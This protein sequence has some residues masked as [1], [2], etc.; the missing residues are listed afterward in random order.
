MPEISTDSILISIAKDGLKTRKQSPSPLKTRDTDQFTRLCINVVDLD[1]K[2][3]SIFNMMSFMLPNKNQRSTYN[4]K[5]DIDTART[6]V[7]DSGV[8]I[9]SV[10]LERPYDC[11]KKKN[12]RIIEAE[13]SARFTESIVFIVTPPNSNSEDYYKSDLGISTLID[14]KNPKNDPL[15]QYTFYHEARLN[16]GIPEKDIIALLVPNHLVETVK[17]YFPT[18]QIIS[19]ENKQHQ[20]K[21]P[22]MMQN[23]LGNKT[24]PVSGP[25]YQAAMHKFISQNNAQKKFAVHATRLPCAYDLA[26]QIKINDKIET[27]SARELFS[28]SKFQLKLYQL[29]SVSE[30]ALNNIRKHQAFI[31]LPLPANQGYFAITEEKNKPLLDDLVNLKEE[32]KSSKA[33]SIKSEEEIL[34]Q[35]QQKKQASAAAVKIQKTWRAYKTRQLYRMFQGFKQDKQDL[36]KDISNNNFTE[37]GHKAK[38]LKDLQDKISKEDVLEGHEFKTMVSSKI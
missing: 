22:D 10:L 38:K 8:G 20:I 30:F 25:D 14:S 4:G 31:L 34:S 15:A 6:L 7:Y 37:A 1:E 16:S 36:E 23:E 29:T 33:E 18:Q 24:Y 17:K 2:P 12:Q 13:L 11:F 5:R 19:V 27:G 28:N 3:S 26:Y 32:I 21:S 35:K 9:A